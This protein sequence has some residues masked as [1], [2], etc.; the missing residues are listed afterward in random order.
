[1]EGLFGLGAIFWIIVMCFAVGSFLALPFIWYHAGFISRKLDRT[2][3]LLALIMKRL[4]QE[5]PGK[6][7]QEK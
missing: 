6:K 7:E 3:Q 1:M 2:N 4:P 5:E